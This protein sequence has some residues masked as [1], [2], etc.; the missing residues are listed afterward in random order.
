M[1]FV[2]TVLTYGYSTWALGYVKRVSHEET[3]SRLIMI[4]RLIDRS[5]SHAG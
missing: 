5:K 3:L 2:P 4:D 1:T